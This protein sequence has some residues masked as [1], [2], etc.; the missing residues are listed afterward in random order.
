MKIISNGWCP[1]CYG[2]S[3][4]ML[5]YY[6]TMYEVLSMTSDDR[7]MNCTMYKL[8]W[9]NCANYTTITQGTHNDINRFV[10]IVL[11][12]FYI[13]HVVKYSSCSGREHINAFEGDINFVL[14]KVCNI[15]VSVLWAKD[16]RS[17][18]HWQYLVKFSLIYVH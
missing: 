17:N 5:L 13:I 12:K 3:F 15:F 8:K 1:L 18:W 9:Q 14:F 11:I 2:F 7:R 10:Y 4:D 16:T 6:S